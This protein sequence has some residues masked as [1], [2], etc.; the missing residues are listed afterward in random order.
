VSRRVTHP[1]VAHNVVLVDFDGTLYP[2]G[3]MF[4][5]P[6]PMP[7]AVTAM[8]ELRESGYRIGI[9]TSRLSPTWHRSE[10]WDT[11]EASKEQRAYIQAVLERDDIPFDFVTC[12][13]VPSVLYLDDKAMRVNRQRGMLRAVRDFQAMGDNAV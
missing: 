6:K 9:F 12:E 8:R 5:F 10:G 1:P 2:W 7:G 4:S 13:K 3:Q 11:N